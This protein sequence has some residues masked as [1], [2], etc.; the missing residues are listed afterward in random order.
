MKD[1]LSH[2]RLIVNNDEKLYEYM[3]LWNGE[4]CAHTRGSVV[5]ARRLKEEVLTV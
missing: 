2:R 3:P 5:A 1:D 4:R